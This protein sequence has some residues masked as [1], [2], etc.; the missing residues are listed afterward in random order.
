MYR[1]VAL[2]TKRGRL[3]ALLSVPGRGVTVG[4]RTSD[5]VNIVER[6][7]SPQR[8]CKIDKV[9]EQDRH[10]R[11]CRNEYRPF[12]TDRLRLGNSNDRRQ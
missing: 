9:R 7:C 11:P 2:D 6:G 12:T 4:E 1:L 8:Q 3:C 5:T 10:Y